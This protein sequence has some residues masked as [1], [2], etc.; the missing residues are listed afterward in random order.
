MRSYDDSEKAV[1]E[2]LDFAR[3]QSIDPNSMMMIRWSFIFYLGKALVLAI[4]T[5]AQVLEDRP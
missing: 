1:F 3:I 2:A 4:L 5:I